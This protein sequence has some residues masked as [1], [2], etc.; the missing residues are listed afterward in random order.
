[1]VKMTMTVGSSPAARSASKA[2]KSLALLPTLGAEQFL[3]LVDRDDES[4]RP[5][6]LVAGDASRR[7]RERVQP[8]TAA[9]PEPP[10][11]RPRAD[12]RGIAPAGCAASAL[13]RPVSPVS[14][15]RS[16]R[17]T[18]KGMNCAS[19]RSS[20][21]RRPARRNEDLPAPEA[22]R[23]ANNRGGA[24]ARSPR[25]RS[26]ASTIGASRPKKMPASSASC[27]FRPR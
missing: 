5:F 21:G 23:I 9:R 10:P 1:M 12:P 6:G 7:R 16:G 18:G 24:P 14:A 27:G 3:R 22:P 11:A 20:L 13:T 19:S 15:A 2:S 17:I 26:M 4:R 8:A 25:S